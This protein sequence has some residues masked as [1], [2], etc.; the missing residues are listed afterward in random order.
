MVA[1]VSQTCGFH[2]G[3]KLVRCG[4]LNQVHFYL[5]YFVG[6]RQTIERVI[7]LGNGRVQSHDQKNG[8]LGIN[9]TV[10]QDP[11]EFAITVRDVG[12][13]QRF[14]HQHSVGAV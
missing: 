7:V 3:L 1:L 6:K 11:R 12:R 13:D 2:L 10:L 8:T 4:P 14:L 9:Q 5:F